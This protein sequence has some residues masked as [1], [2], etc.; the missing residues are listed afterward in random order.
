MSAVTLQ[1]RRTWLLMRN[2]LSVARNE[3]IVIAATSGVA[4]ILYVLTSIGGGSPQFHLVVYPILLIV[5]GYIVSSFSFQEIHD[6]RSGVYAL[7]SPGSTLEK[8]VA[9]ILLTS[10]G[11]TIVVTLAYMVT[12]AIGAGV[13]GLILGESHGIFVPN[14]GVFWEIIGTYL[15][16][17]SIFVFGSIYF[18]KAAFFKTVLV[19]VLLAI[20]YAFFFA[21]VL[22]VAYWN[23]FTRIIPTDAQINA[24]IAAVPPEG[25]RVAEALE[26]V[27]DYIGWIVV[28]IF[29]W[30]AG[31]VRLRETEV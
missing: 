1:P 2:D 5:F 27:I 8:Y 13:A 25:I 30:F 23:V 9:R 12:T 18:K 15:V 16:S 14:N 17:Q 3:A 11:W 10:I 20:I 7:T 26:R 21:V 6:P 24:F 31:Y 22:R 4:L 19:A 28:P 29:F